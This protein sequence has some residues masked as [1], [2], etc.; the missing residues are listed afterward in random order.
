MGSALCGRAPLGGSVCLGPRPRTLEAWPRWPEETVTTNPL[1]AVDTISTLFQWVFLILGGL[2]AVA[3]IGE[4]SRSDTPAEFY[5]LLLTLIAGM[6]VV[7]S[8]DELILLFLGLELI[9]IPTYVLLYLARRDF[10]SQ[11]AATKYFLLSVLSAAILLYG[12]SFLYGLTGTT[13]LTAIRHVLSQSYASSSMEMP[14]AAPSQLGI[15]ALTL[16]FAGLGFKMTAVPFHFYAPDVYQGTTAW[17]AGL[18][19]VAPKAAGFVALI[20]V[21]TQTLSGYEASGETIALILAMVTM[22]GGNILALLQT[23]IRRLLAY[24]SIAHAGYMLIG[25]AVGFWESWN[26]AQSLDSQFG[27]PGGIEASLFYLIAYSLVT[28]GLFIVLVYLARPGKQIE[29]VE[30]LTGLRRTHP[31]VAVSAA[32]FLFSLAGVPPLPGFWAKLGVFAGAL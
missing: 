3:S 28:A 27:L 13:Q 32:I 30:E 31:W 11:E 21:S 22:T 9:S 29:H 23:N 24:S 20:R 1:V 25:V 12:F 7:A 26:P 5:G 17:N 14:I 4:Q 15:V 16:I 6:M 8:A 2:F 10:A 18:L 19:A